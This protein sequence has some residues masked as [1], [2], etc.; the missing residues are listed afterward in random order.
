MFRKNWKTNGG[1]KV[2]MFKKSIVATCW[3]FCVVTLF[4]YGVNVQAKSTALIEPCKLLSKSDA[5]AIMATPFKDGQYSESR[6]VGQKL[7]LY[8]AVDENSFTFLQISLPQNNFMLPSVLTSG[9][10][11]RT[12]FTTI[13]EAFP[14]REDI[15][16]I[17]DEAFIATPGIHILKGDYYITIGAGNLKRNKDKVIA[18]GRKAL[19]NLD[20]L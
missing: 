15:S 11:A 9:Q 2:M 5:E 4:G 10:N 13:K 12:I 17:G 14:D 16:G 7:C 3:L 18:A 6:A 8:E 19:A 1:E 20:A